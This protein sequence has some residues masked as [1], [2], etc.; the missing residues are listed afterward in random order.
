[1][2]DASVGTLVL[3]MEEPVLPGRRVHP[4][5]LMGAVDGTLGPG[6]DDALLIGA[7]RVIGPED[8]LPACRDTTGRR[9][10]V[11]LPVPPV[12]LGPFD[13]RLAQVAVV[14]DP[15][16]SQE[17][18]PVRVHR[19]HEKDTLEARPRTSATV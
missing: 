4:G 12:E 5:A 6:H 9:E 17:P 2:D 14:H 19:R 11:I 1:M 3:E 7:E 18:G 13:G 15:G 8:R 10:D 16:R